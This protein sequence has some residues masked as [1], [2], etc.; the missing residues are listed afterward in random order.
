MKR[1]TM[2]LLVLLIT[3][4]D[5]A[6]DSKDEVTL[7]VVGEG[8]TREE[9][10]NNALR[11]AVAQAYGVFVSANTQIL[12]D[13]LVKDEIATV[14]SGNIKEYK[15]ITNLNLPNGRKEVTLQTVV[16][17]SKLISYAMSKGASAEF[18][19]DVFARNMKIREL[20][21]TNERKAITSF[22][23][24]MKF[25]LQMCYERRLTV[26]EPSLTSKEAGGAKEYVS[27]PMKIEF[28]PNNN[29]NDFIISFQKLFQA[30]SLSKAEVQE[31]L[32]LGLNVTECNVCSNPKKSIMLKKIDLNTIGANWLRDEGRNL[33]LQ[34]DSAIS[35]YFTYFSIKDNTGQVSI[36]EGLAIP[37]RR[38]RSSY[39][40]EW[41]ASTCMPYRQTGLFS[42][43]KEYNFDRSGYSPT[44]LVISYLPNIIS[45]PIGFISGGKYQG[46]AYGYELEWTKESIIVNYEILIPSQEIGKYSKFELLN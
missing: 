1:F 23:Q 28:V 16:S 39:D 12:N 15:E 24:Q 31:Y 3:V 17:I 43:M 18:A 36:F 32:K 10:T 8:I 25:L 7:T 9:A 37:N 30:L 46:Q 11:S 19:G 44:L 14:T 13:S 4:A 22:F 38:N 40:T 33:E 45:E 21:K 27:I 42:L 20:N 5:I 2:I 29:L 41:T 26:S 34:L 6:Q 35:S